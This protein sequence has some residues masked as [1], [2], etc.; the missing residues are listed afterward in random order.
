MIECVLLVALFSIQQIKRICWN[1]LMTSCG[2]LIVCLFCMNLSYTHTYTCMIL[3]DWGGILFVVCCYFRCVTAIN[4]YRIKINQN[5]DKFLSR[6]IL[7]VPVAECLTKNHMPAHAAWNNA[8]RSTRALPSP[9][10]LESHHKQCWCDLRHY[11]IIKK[12]VIRI[13]NLYILI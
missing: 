4:C 12:Y 2:Q 11:Q 10:K 13:A 7:G 6:N 5:P 3:K 9:V 8:R 1:V